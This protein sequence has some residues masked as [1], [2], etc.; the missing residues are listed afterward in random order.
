MLTDQFGYA[1][2]RLRALEGG[3]GAWDAAGYSL[4]K[5]ASVDSK[6]RRLTQW[7]RIKSGG[8]W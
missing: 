7:G 2:E 8:R 4:Q 6:R 3:I 1:N 5:S